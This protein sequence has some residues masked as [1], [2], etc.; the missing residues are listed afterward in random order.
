MLFSVMHFSNDIRGDYYGFIICGAP[1]RDA[2]CTTVK[3]D[4]RSTSHSG[5]PWKSPIYVVHLVD[6]IIYYK[7][8]VN[9][10]LRSALHTL[11]PETIVLKSMEH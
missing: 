11:V 8:K 3:V 4:K 10:P 7:R 1:L 9:P 2:T 5:V 6:I